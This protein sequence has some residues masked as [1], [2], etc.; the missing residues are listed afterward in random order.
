MVR[1]VV[2]D[3]VVDLGGVVALVAVAG[4][5]ADLKRGKIITVEIRCSKLYYIYVRYIQN[6]KPTF[7]P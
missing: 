3:D 5:A 7:L 6:K 2:V 1:E 4:D